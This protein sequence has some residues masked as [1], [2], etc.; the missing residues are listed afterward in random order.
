MRIGGVFS[1]IDGTSSETTPVHYVVV[2]GH[3]GP[4]NAPPV[5][6]I[7]VC[8]FPDP[9]SIFEGELSRSYREVMP[10]VMF[11]HDGA[12]GSMTWV[13]LQGFSGQL[14]ENTSNRVYDIPP[15]FPFDRTTLTELDADAT[16]VMLAVQHERPLKSGMNLFLGAGLGRYSMDATGFSVD[17]ALPANA[18]SVSGSFDGTRAQ[19]S[20]GIEKP[21]GK[22]LSLGA[23]VRADYWTDQPRVQMDWTTPPCTPSLCNPPSRI[24]NFSLTSDPMLSV[25]VG[26]S[27]TLRM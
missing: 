1:G 23:T 16:G 7:R 12:D 2:A 11:G 6:E 8:S 15:G 5:A 17:P 4:G 18:K 25:T 21:V 14:T 19:L 24:G 9:C 13:G 10:E 27:L 22:G 20:V 3:G 26:V